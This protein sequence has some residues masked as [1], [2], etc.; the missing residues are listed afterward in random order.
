MNELNQLLFDF[1]HKQN[2]NYDD[3]YVSKS[4]FFAFKLVEDWPKWEKNIVNIMLPEGYQVESLP[5]SEV[6]EFA[7]GKIKYSFILKQNGNFIQLSTEFDLQTPFVDSADYVVFK[8]FFG[9]VVAKQAEQI[10][11]SKQ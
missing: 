6:M 5:Q 11:L 4:N 1:N 8:E 2:F 3:F 7:D 9:K 10:V